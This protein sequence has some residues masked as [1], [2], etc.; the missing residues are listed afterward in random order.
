MEIRQ[1]EYVVA[2]AEERS[3]SRAAER[4]H[5]AQPSLSQQI[6]KLEA[7]LRVSLFDRLPRGVVVTEAGARLVARARTVLAELVDARR[8]VGETKTDVAG[9]LRVGAIPTIAPF[10]LPGCVG[11]FAGRW[12]DVAVHVVEDVTDRLVD[13]VLNGDLDLAITSSIADDRAVHVECI[14]RERLWVLAPAESSL[15]RRKSVSWTAFDKQRT[16]VLHEDH[17]LAGQVTRFCRGGK[18]KPSVVSRGAQLATIARMV[19]ADLGVSVVPDMMKRQD[20]SRSRVYLPFARG[21]PQRELCIVWG[22]LR[23]RTNA[24]RAFEEIVRAFVT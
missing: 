10:V 7:E 22:M 21:R 24:A 12:P 23:Y 8:E 3:F 5:V 18:A 13:G 2:I 1:L 20:R 11:R 14:A 17:C 9:T 15:A 16:L 4:L 6:K 19:S